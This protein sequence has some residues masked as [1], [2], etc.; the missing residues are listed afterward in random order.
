MKYSDSY[1]RL[2]PTVKG[3][4]VSYRID[5]SEELTELGNTKFKFIYGKST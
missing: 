4:R 2:P 3:K 1:M 5:N